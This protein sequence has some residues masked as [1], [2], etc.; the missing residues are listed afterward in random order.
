MG[1]SS[2]IDCQEEFLEIMAYSRLRFSRGQVDKA[3][4]NFIK[5]SSLALALPKDEETE[6]INNWRLSHALPL[7]VIKRTLE[8]RAKRI[9]PSANVAKRIKRLSSIEAK[10]RNLSGFRL[11]QIQD[12][13]G[14]RAILSGINDV[15]KLA[16]AYAAK[17]K[18]TVRVKDDYI[19]QPKSDG[20]R[21]MHLVATYKS[22]SSAY[23][24]YDGLKIEIQLRSKLQHAWATAVETVS[25][26][27]SIPVRS[28]DSNPQWRRFFA[29]MGTAI[30]RR[31][32]QS[33][34]PG[35]ED[36]DVAYELSQLS[37]ALNVRYL[38]SSWT[39]A[40]TYTLPMHKDSANASDF[41]LVLDSDARTGSTSSFPR[42]DSRRAFEEYFKTERQFRGKPNVQV[43][44]VSVE[45]ID[46]LREA[47][48]NYY[49]D[50]GVFLEALRFATVPQ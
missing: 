24:I 12:I 20:Y 35:T 44:L 7:L 47:Y 13:G 25:T 27:T 42:G 33:V 34:V 9:D 14:C 40:L 41:L 19:A 17:N 46:E 11:T 39:H 29:L 32:H 45:S 4:A 21:S 26:F 10:L 6:V 22:K 1:A 5:E 43:V 3:G 23:A 38:L 31:E 49:A 28:E 48:P 18:S 36:A 37:A 2:V 15:F 30:A 8:N 16:S 50:T